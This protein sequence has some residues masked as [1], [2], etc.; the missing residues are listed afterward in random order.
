MHNAPA[1]P[2][3]QWPQGGPPHLPTPD[4]PGGLY[5]VLSESVEWETAKDADDICV[6]AVGTQ[7][8]QSHPGEPAR[9]R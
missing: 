6:D 8:L 5:K 4:T 9:P 1:L 7:I 3:F 2:Q